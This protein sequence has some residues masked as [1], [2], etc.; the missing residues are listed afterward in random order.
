[1]VFQVSV[2]GDLGPTKFHSKK[3]GSLK[4][5][6]KRPTCEI[7]SGQ[8]SRRLD[9]LRP[10]AR[11]QFQGHEG[12]VTGDIELVRFWLAWSSY[13][14][15]SND[16]ASRSAGAE[17]ARQREDCCTWTA[18]NRPPEEA[19][20]HLSPPSA[21][22]NSLDTSRITVNGWLELLEQVAAGEEASLSSDANQET[23][24]QTP[25][26]S[27]W[28]RVDGCRETIPSKFEELE[29]PQGERGLQRG[30]SSVAISNLW[31]SSN[32]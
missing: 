25:R 28:A 17:T 27:C 9:K 5:L 2:R 3:I 26:M 24:M 6:P 32:L 19:D 30:P 21:S 14:N 18:P 29:N 1:M 23:K 22:P 8:H 16:K 7:S 31:S 11:Q 10:V 20:R 13:G 15:A 12:W 4:S